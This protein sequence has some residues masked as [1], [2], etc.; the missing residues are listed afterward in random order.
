M[1]NKIALN[2]L[3]YYDGVTDKNG[4]AMTWSIYSIIYLKLSENE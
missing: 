3:E 4:P 1:E 2:D